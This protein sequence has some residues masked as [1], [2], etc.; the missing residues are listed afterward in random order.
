MTNI[1]IQSY[2]G[3]DTLNIKEDILPAECLAKLKV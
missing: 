2:M 1:I 3:K